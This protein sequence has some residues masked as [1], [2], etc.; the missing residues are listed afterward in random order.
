MIEADTNVGGSV[1]QIAIEYD[2]HPEDD[3]TVTGTE[4]FELEQTVKAVGR[5][6]RNLGDVTGKKD[7]VG[8]V[9]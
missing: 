8:G 2:L 4:S 7:C 1:G 5:E 6:S 3:I 9:V